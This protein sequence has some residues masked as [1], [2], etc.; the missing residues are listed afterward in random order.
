MGLG[1]GGISKFGLWV[2]GEIG[3]EGFAQGVL[4]GVG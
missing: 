4:F 3:P 2:F 1:E